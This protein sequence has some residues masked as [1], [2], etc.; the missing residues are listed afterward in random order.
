MKQQLLTDIGIPDLPIGSRLVDLNN[1]MLKDFNA[2]F[3]WVRLPDGSY[4]VD[5]SYEHIF[6]GLAVYLKPYQRMK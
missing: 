6:K 2:A 4:F 3:C 5:F 1:Y